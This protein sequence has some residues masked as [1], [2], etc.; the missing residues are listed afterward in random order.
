MKIV[1]NRVKHFVIPLAVVILCVQFVQ[2]QWQP[3]QK[4]DIN[5]ESYT[6][7]ILWETYDANYAERINEY[8]GYHHIVASYNNNTY[9]VYID[10]NWQPRVVKVGSDG[11]SEEAYLDAAGYKILEN[12]SHQFFAIGV[13]KLGYIHVFGDMHNFPRYNSDHLPAR[14]ANAKCMYWRSD[15][16]EDIS[17]FTFYGNK[18]G[19]CPYGTSFTYPQIFYDQDGGIYFSARVRSETARQYAAVNYNRYNEATKQWEHIGGTNEFNN[20]CLFYEDNGEDGGTYS[21][22][23]RNLHFDLN[24]RAHFVSSLYN[25]DGPKP[26]PETNSKYNSDLVYAASDD[27]GNTF[28]RADGTAITKIPMRIDAEA[29]RPD[30]LMQGA[31]INATTSQAITDYSGKVYATGVHYSESGVE[32]YYCYT[33]DE[34]IKLWKDVSS[35]RP[36]AKGYF[37]TDKTGVITF[38]EK[39]TSKIHRFFEFDQSRVMEYEFFDIGID[40]SHMLRTGN[41]RGI[42]RRTSSSQPFRLV[43]IEINRPVSYPVIEKPVSVDEKKL[44]FSGEYLVYPNPVKDYLTVELKQYLKGKITICDLLGRKVLVKNFSGN[45]VTLDLRSVNTGM[46]LLNVDAD[47]TIFKTQNIVVSN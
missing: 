39:N 14:Y 44:E 46:Y 27:F 30:V 41:I 26:L 42:P 33:F 18:F 13:D 40:R 28:K 16:P 25:H 29:Q 12:D 24:N 9:I 22:P 21:K 8:R 47:K 3:G 32:K 17:G 31:I 2:A 15:K 7:R 35:I 38:F 5:E 11:T 4:Y 37:V 10:N 36:Q 1:S 43:E 23:C 19:D 45:R 34:T 20:R 6:T